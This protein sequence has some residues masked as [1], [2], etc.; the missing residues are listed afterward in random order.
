MAAHGSINAAIERIQKF[1]NSPSHDNDD[2]LPS[3]EVG[4]DAV[5]ESLD[6][7]EKWMRQLLF[8]A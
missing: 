4:I 6:A 8:D 3:S 5:I 1:T 2:W 7:I